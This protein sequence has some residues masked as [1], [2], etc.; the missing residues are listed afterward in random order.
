M[1]KLTG[2]FFPQAVLL[3]CLAAYS[4]DAQA[5]SDRFRE[6]YPVVKRQGDSMARALISHD[7]DLFIRFT[8]LGLV[9]KMG[10]EEAYAALLEKSMEDISAGG[11]TITETT[12]DPP[13]TIVRQ[14]ETLQCTVNEHITMKSEQGT[15]KSLS[16]LIAVSA[17]E[18]LTWRFL[19]TS[20]ATLDDMR[21][22]FPELST[23]LI[24]P[25]KEQPQF[26]PE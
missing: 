17:D 25:K 22:I 23:T 13:T 10:G 12:V 1:N 8:Y 21:A 5:Q 2:F 6:M 11:F 3:A 16:T 24:I 26:L 19:D 9:K 4:P 7:N 15:I 20:G 14:K 18:G